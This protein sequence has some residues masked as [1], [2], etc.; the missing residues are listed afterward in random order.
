M[1]WRQETSP[2]PEGVSVFPGAEFPLA[3]NAIRDAYTKYWQATAIPTIEQQLHEREM[4]LINTLMADFCD[5]YLSAPV[6]SAAMLGPIVDAYTQSS[7]HAAAVAA[8]RSYIDHESAETRQYV[9]GIVADRPVLTAFWRDTV[10]AQSQNTPEIHNLLQS[11]DAIHVTPEQWGSRVPLVAPDRILSLLNA[12]NLESL[13]IKSVETLVQL[14]PATAKNNSDTFIQ[15]YQAESLLAPLCE[16]IG[17]DGL[18]MA[19]QSRSYIIRSTFTD[20]TEP[21]ERATALV[22]ERGNEHQV[23][24]DVQALFTAVFGE[25]I[26]EQVIRHAAPHGIIIGEGLCTRDNLRVVWRLKSIGSLARKLN[27]NKSYPM[28]IIGATVIAHNETQLAERLGRII[29][30]SHDDERIRL[31]PTTERTDAVHVK[32]T[33]D[34]IETIRKGLGF[35][36]LE[37]MRRF[38]DV[39]EV[40][41]GEHRVSKVTLVFRQDNRPDL[42]AEIQLTTAA[43][44]IEARI[45]S[46]AHLLYKFSQHAEKPIDPNDLAAIRARKDKLNPTTYHLNPLSV[47]RGD[48]LCRELTRPA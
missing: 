47:M 14:D 41:P 45:G 30:H 3:P 33:P 44:R 22:N 43:D 37:S 11:C 1:T 18:A 31:T 34:Y 46:A 12:V 38:V 29:D 23:D 17:F 13:L 2:T 6:Y 21:V 8:L 10:D 20:N 19:L 39:K 5:D 42:R 24:D 16:I 48:A 4:T 7:T 32:G 28:D 36:S 35:D 9:L 25:H 26:H 15:L 27:D 40:A